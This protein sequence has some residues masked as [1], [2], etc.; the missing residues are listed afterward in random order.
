MKAFRPTA[1][2]ASI[3]IAASSART[4]ITFADQVRWFNGAS[5]TVY[6]KFGDSSV[7]ATTSDIPV[8]AGVTEVM[9][10]PFGATHIAAIG[11][12]ATGSFKVTPGIGI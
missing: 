12:G 4:A 3:T 6:V 7:A 5:E 10:V 8:G 9:D 2:T 11:T 1:A